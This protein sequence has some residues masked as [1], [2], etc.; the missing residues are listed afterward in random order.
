MRWQTVVVAVHVLTFL[1]CASLSDSG[2]PAAPTAARLDQAFTLAAGAVAV[3]DAEH[4]QVGFDRVLS[5]SR[6]PRGAQC[7]VEGEA[8]VRVWLSKSPRGKDNRDLKTTPNAL[9]A[10]YDAYRIKLVTLE[11]YP[12][13]ERAVRPSEY[14][15]T[16][17]V[18]RSR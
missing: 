15:A 14:V 17:L 10:V 11:P 8:T 3:F 13:V 1:A 2:S 6:C 4:L 12:G 9:E 7:I 16:L 5:D 18:S